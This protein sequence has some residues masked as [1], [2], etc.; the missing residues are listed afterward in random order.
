MFSTI[1]YT[2]KYFYYMSPFG[3]CLNYQKHKL[4]KEISK[5]LWKKL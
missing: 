4:S 1:Y 2:I 3:Y 5:E